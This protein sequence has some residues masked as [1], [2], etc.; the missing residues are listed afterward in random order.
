[1]I[2][3]A[4]LII[5]D[6]HAHYGV[7]DEQI[8]HAEGSIG[9]PVRQVVVLGDFGFFGDEL[10]AYFRRVRRRF[11]RPVATIEGNH[12]DHAALENLAALYSDVVTFLPRGSLHPVGEWS[13]LCLGGARY[14]DSAATP[15][16]SEITEHDLAACLAHAPDAVDLVFTHDCPDD[17]GVPGERGMA[18]YGKPGVPGMSRLADRY[19]PRFWFFGHHHRW[20]DLERGGTRYVGLPQSWDGYVLLDA[21]GRIEC[22]NHAVSI[23]KRPWWRRWLGMQ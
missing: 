13:G 16:G 4:V 17:I 20:F 1:M 2:R 15:R 19:Q 9:G 10:Q 7:I 18:H 6:I 12:E 5:G 21:N 14:M 8:I 22:V 11:L 23:R 3:S